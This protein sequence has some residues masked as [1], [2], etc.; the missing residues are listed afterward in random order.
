MVETQRKVIS[1]IVGGYYKVLLAQESTIVPKGK[2]G[3]VSLVQ[4]LDELEL[5]DTAVHIIFP[6]EDSAKTAINW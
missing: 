6:D 3:A 4:W 5:G 2:L 1:D